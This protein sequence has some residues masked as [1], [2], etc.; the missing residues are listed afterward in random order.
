M[1][2]IDR[3]YASLSADVLVVGGGPAGTWAAIKAAQAGA[4]R[5]TSQQIYY[6]LQRLCCGDGPAAESAESACAWWPG[7]RSC[8]P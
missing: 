8:L 4:P 3:N 2:D 1:S 5:F 6:P 7:G